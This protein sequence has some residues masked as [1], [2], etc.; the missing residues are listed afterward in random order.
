MYSYV[1]DGDEFGKKAK[2]VK[3]YVVKKYITHDDYRRT[4][5][6]GIQMRH[7][8]NKERLS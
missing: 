3:K 8:H 6:E 5:K 1:G 2:G 4:L 7:E